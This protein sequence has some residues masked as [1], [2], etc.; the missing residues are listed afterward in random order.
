M[1]VP[2]KGLQR[3]LTPTAASMGNKQI[4]AAGRYFSPSLV[5]QRNYAPANTLVGSAVR[6]GGTDGF[7]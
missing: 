3:S 6:T 2:L 4:P 5:N 1:Y 7:S